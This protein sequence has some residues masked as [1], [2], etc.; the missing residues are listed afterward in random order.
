MESSDSSVIPCL[1][2]FAGPAGGGRSD[3][4]GTERSDVLGTAVAAWAASV[5]RYR[6]S[7]APPG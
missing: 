4:A 5:P 2:V 1:A 3:P 7:S 6:S